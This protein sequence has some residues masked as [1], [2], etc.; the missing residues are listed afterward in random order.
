AAGGY[1]HSDVQEHSTGSGDINTGRFMIYGG[2]WAGPTLW[3]ATAGYAHDSINTSRGFPG[4]GTAREAHSGN[5]ASVGTQA[6]LPMVMNGA[7]VT[8][9]VGLP[10]LHLSENAFAETGA[11]GLDLSNGGRST[12]SLQPYLAVSAA[13]TFAMPGG[14]ELTP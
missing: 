1:L 11:N 5:E 6:S 8:P 2:G 3:T 4:V 7:T 14:A 13:Q 10:F 12:N 9:K